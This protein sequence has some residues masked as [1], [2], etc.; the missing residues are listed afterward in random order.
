MLSGYTYS[1]LVGQKP[2]A[3]CTFCT[4]FVRLLTPFRIRKQRYEPSITHPA[5]CRR[6]CPPPE[7]I[8]RFHIATPH[9]HRCWRWH[10]FHR[11]RQHR[12]HGALRRT[13]NC[14]HW[15]TML[16]ARRHKHHTDP[17]ATHGRNR[18]TKPQRRIRDAVCTRV[19]PHYKFVSLDCRLRV[20][21]HCRTLSK[22]GVAIGE[23]VAH[24]N[25]TSRRQDGGQCWNL[26]LGPAR[27]VEAHQRHGLYPYICWP[28]QC[29]NHSNS[30][31]PHVLTR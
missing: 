29:D 23:Y 10:R 18:D 14:R 16:V 25:G 9:G 20:T 21:P 15:R 4:A 31:E 30:E 19:R 5:I 26:V 1:L 11:G 3:D 2:P 17:R 27:R 22:S 7:W 12:S 28:H 13:S 24:K 8:C 6:H